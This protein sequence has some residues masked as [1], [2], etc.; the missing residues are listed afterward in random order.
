MHLLI[1][2]PR[3]RL[4]PPAAT[5]GDSPEPVPPVA[6]S[7]VAGATGAPGRAG[8]TRCSLELAAR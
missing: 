1:S 4:P 3:R 2:G 6:F 7:R 8:S 5:A